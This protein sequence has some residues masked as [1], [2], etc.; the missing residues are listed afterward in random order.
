MRL[1][2]ADDTIMH[3]CVV[4]GNILVGTMPIS[5]LAPIF[6]FFYVTS[7]APKM[8]LWSTIL[9]GV[10][11]IALDYLFI[12]V[13]KYEVLGVALATCAGDLVVCALGVFLRQQKAC[14]AF[15][16]AL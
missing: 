12:V 4:Y 7:G 5:I 8:G 3:Y 14:G 13:L 10:V 1:L 16:E 6:E 15:C 2:G 11:N 9:R